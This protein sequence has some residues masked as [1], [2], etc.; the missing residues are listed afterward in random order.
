M[1]KVEE[2]GDEPDQ[3]WTYYKL[4]FTFLS[5]YIFIFSKLNKNV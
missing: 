5:L 2:E 1:E 4:N 3:L